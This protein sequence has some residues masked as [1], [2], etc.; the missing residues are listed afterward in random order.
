ML[1]LPIQLK[2]C[3]SML[4][5]AIFRDLR[6][7]APNPEKMDGVI[8]LK[9]SNAATVFPDFDGRGANRAFSIIIKLLLGE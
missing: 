3:T 9:P 1:Y 4:R 8:G 5:L 6:G 7:D 2:F